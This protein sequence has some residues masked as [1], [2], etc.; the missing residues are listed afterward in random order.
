MLRFEWPVDAYLTGFAVEL[1]DADGRALPREI[2]H[3][4]IG[5]NYDRRQLVYP[6]LERTFGWGTE[7]EKVTLPTGVGVPMAAGQ[8]LGFYV[9][10]H[11]ETAREIRGA[12]LLIRIPY[13]AARTIKV[14]VLP[15][16]VDVRN[17][18]GG[19]TTFLVPPGR[20]EQAYEFTVPVSGR[21][22]AIGGHI[23][24]YGVAMRLEDAVSGKVL[25]RLKAKRDASGHVLAVP[26]FIWGFHE[27]A[28]PLTAG[29]R[30][31]VVSEYD[32][33]SGHPVEAGGMGQLN[34]AFEPDDLARW[35]RLDTS[36]PE[37]QRDI[38]ALPR[39][40]LEN[41]ASS[42]GIDEPKEPHNRTLPR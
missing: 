21:M 24:D 12:R 37:L 4:L 1:R 31:R 8:R 18:I 9:A 14:A 23:H 35:P 26:R 29:H 19:V 22:I 15:F 33:T 25:V 5:V 20:S 30:Y 39:A 3:H 13:A 32:N 11:N 7:T 2:L 40:G 10:W 42:P 28:L 27:D 6:A 34:G 16:Y 17:V 36:D 38:A 41:P